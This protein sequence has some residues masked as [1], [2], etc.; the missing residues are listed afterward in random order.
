MRY[1]RFEGS[2]LPVRV[3]EE[4]MSLGLFVEA[5]VR[6]TAEMNLRV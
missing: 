3:V 2:P 5:V 6:A 1:E 4:T